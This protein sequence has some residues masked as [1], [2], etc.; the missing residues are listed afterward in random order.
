MVLPVSRQHWNNWGINRELTLL[1]LQ[2]DCVSS[3]QVINPRR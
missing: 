1:F 2:V 3:N